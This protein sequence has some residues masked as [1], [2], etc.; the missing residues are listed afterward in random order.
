[1]R[2]G[3]VKLIARLPV[4]GPLYLKGLLRAI[5]RTPR[6]KLPPQLQQVQSMLKQIPAE[7]RVQLLRASLRGELPRQEQVGR[8]LR[9]AAERQAKRR[10]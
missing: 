2:Q 1:M 6:Q 8:E 10:R 7:Q 3:L 9:R 5:E 4:V